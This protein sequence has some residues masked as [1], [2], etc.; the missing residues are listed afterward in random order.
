MNDQTPTP[1]PDER[2]SSQI[3]ELLPALTAGRALHQ[4]TQ[5][6]VIAGVESLASSR[7]I[8]TSVGRN[9]ALQGYATLMIDANVRD[10]SLHN[11]FRVGNERGLS[12]LLASTEP[13]N[14]LVQ[15][16][17]IPNLSIIP[18]GPRI[19]NIS[20]LLTS[21][22]VFHRVQPI[23][24]HYDLVIADCSRLPSSL[25]GSVAQSADSIIILAERHQ[26]SLRQ[27][28]AFVDELR[29]KGTVQPTV[30]IVES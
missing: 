20:G 24:R 3:I 21:E 10:P 27:L 7:I 15:D 2:L 5:R 18:A 6:V 8:V 26:T 1:V 29:G 14:R 25:V 17:A 4:V 23:S 19:A 16:T 12:T 22:D 11:A 13:P 30:L 28:T 9:C